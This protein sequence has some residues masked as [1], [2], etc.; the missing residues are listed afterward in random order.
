M[1]HNDALKDLLDCFLYH[2]LRGF[3]DCFLCNYFFNLVELLVFLLSSDGS[4]NYQNY[5]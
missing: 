2:A 1:Y 4:K 5:L 3:L